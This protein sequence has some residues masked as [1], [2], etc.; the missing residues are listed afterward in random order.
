[1]LITKDHEFLLRHPNPPA[2]FKKAA[3]DPALRSD[4]YLRN[5]VFQIDFLATFPLNGVATVVIGQAENTEARSS[6]PWV[7]TL[8]HEHF[9]QLQYS[10]PGYYAQV[11]ELGL[12]RGDQSGMWMLNFPFPYSE[13]NVDKRFTELCQ[14]LAKALESG[15]AGQFANNL[16]DYVKARKRFAESLSSDDYKY[17]SLQLWQEG[18]SRYTE[19]RVAKEAA[20]AYTP[21]EG[22]KSL[23][24]FTPFDQVAASILKRI[25]SDLAQIMLTRRQRVAFYSVGAAEA[26][27]ADLARTNWQ[28]RYFSERFSTETY[29]LN[30]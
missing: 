24:D 23:T 7:V 15:G 12:A 1:L 5:R 13:P 25:K 27:V 9:H 14:L 10:Q 19:Y 26:M 3:H 29:L 30:R 2:D 11:A 28:E 8:L 4:V 18:V 16:A 21:T 20:S 22:F 17:L 6:T